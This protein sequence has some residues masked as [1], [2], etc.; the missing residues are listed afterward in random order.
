MEPYCLLYVCICAISKVFWY[1]IVCKYL[2][3]HCVKYLSCWSQKE[4]IWV[5]I[6]SNIGHADHNRGEGMRGER[7]AE[8][9][10]FLIV[11]L[12]ISLQYLCRYAGYNIGTRGEWGAE[13]GARGEKE[14]QKTGLW[15][16]LERT[17][18]SAPRVPNCICANITA[19]FLQILLK[20]Y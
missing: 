1:H 19:V 6:G 7:G 11:F 14:E 16:N 15:W 4:N 13:A 20:C 18:S 8:N 3:P 2:S 12:Q 17:R 10:A 9:H 5:R